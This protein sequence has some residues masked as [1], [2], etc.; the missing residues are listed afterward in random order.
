ML[1]KKGY[2]NESKKNSENGVIAY[3]NKKEIK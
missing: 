3:T 2:V 1:L